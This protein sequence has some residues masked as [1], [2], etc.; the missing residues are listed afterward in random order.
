MA[1]VQNQITTV[2]TAVDNISR[3]SANIDKNVSQLTKSFTKLS[4]AFQNAF[5][6]YVRFRIFGLINQGIS[7]IEGA[8]PGL[9]A[10]GQEWARTVDDVADST[11]LAAGQ[12]S[13]FAGVAQVMTGNVEG[14][15]KA[16]GA[17]AQQTVNHGDVLKRYGIQTRDT[18]GT[19][20][21]TWTILGNVRKALSDTGNSFITTAAARDLFSRGG[22]T[23]LDFLTLSQPAFR[24]LIRDVRESGAVMTEQGLQIADQFERTKR[25]FD[26]QITGLGNTINQVL[27]PVLGRLIDGITNLIRDNLSE[28]VSFVSTVVGFVVGVVSSLTGIDISVAS[29][30]ENQDK[31]G[32]SNDRLRGKL[33]RL[34]QSRQE[35]T[36]TEDAFTDAIKRQIDAIDRQLAALT[37]AERAENARA[38]QKRLLAEISDAK[39]ELNELRGKAIFAAGMSNREAELARQAQAAD[40]IEAQKRI[41]ESRRKLA[42]FQKKQAIDERRFE[43]EQRRTALQ[44]QLNSHVKMLA[45]RN[46]AD[47][48]AMAQLVSN[49][50]A[51]FGKMTK[52]IQRAMAA[53]KKAFAE[54]FGKGIEFAPGLNSLLFGK[55]DDEGNVVADGLAQHLQSAA[56]NVANLVNV[57][58]DL[59]DFLIETSIDTPLG[60]VNGLTAGLALLLAPKFISLLRVVPL[61]MGSAL[62]GLAVAFSTT[63]VI[64]LAIAALGVAAVA[65]F[66]EAQR[67]S[68]DA[69]AAADS[70]ASKPLQENIDAIKRTLISL[71]IIKTEAGKGPLEGGIAGGIATLGFKTTLHGATETAIT[72]ALVKA[73]SDPRAT[74][75]QLKTLAADVKAFIPLLAWLGSAGPVFDNIKSLA[76]QLDKRLTGEDT[77]DKDV[78]VPMRDNTAQMTTALTK[79]GYLAGALDTSNRYLSRIAFPR[80]GTVWGIANMDVFLDKDLILTIAGVP[81][82][83]GN[84]TLRP[85]SA[86]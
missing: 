83:Q 74:P 32:K 28:I 52:N 69:Q 8:I 62:T 64:G 5:Q 51:G 42:E 55:R 10:R 85:Q 23:L 41:A 43:L 82:Q 56:T 14:L 34:A 16:L 46:Q 70:L 57:I 49:N 53:G 81:I 68:A 29:F 38:E 27:G 11:G 44:E 48:E 77:R 9:I 17:L 6:F 22:Q 35:Q 39:R 59:H 66:S 60:K 58:S 79:T 84:S 19:L 67:I 15:T 18:N 2:F 40:V 25:R 4:G 7:A 30:A 50:A 47:R 80:P 61:V 26:L 33:D 75:E 31:A 65:V 45:E 54:A 73:L 37:R 36:R 86:R 72:N 24:M 12:A 78:F 76:S 1:Q 63:G 71:S 13:V 21:D 20:L 3:T